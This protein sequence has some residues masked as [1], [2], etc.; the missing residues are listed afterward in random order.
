MT[1]VQTCALPICNLSSPYLY[2]NEAI[3]YIDYDLDVKVFPNGTYRLLDENE[4]KF[5][6]DKMNYPIDVQ[7]IIEKEVQDLIKKVKN[8]EGPFSHEKVI[9]DFNLAF[10]NERMKLNEK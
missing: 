4:Y 6:L 9:K 7:E 1:G 5:H 8:K 10:P 2:D 3:K